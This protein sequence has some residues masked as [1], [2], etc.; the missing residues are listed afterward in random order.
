M[1]SAHLSSNIVTQGVNVTHKELSHNQSCVGMQGPFL[2]FPRNNDYLVLHATTHTCILIS[3][4]FEF[5]GIKH[6]LCLLSENPMWEN[7]Q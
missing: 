1:V 5:F 2:G 3:L 4:L 7:K 6:K